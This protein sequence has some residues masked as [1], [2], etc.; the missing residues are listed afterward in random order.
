[1]VSLGGIV[2]CVLLGVPLY[3]ARE[4]A[5]YWRKETVKLAAE[6]DEFTRETAAPKK[7]IAVLE[8]QKEQMSEEIDRLNGCVDKWADKASF[9]E[10]KCAFLAKEVL[11]LKAAAK[12]KKAKVSK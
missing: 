6:Y 5:E 3:R 7:D 4:R 9:A 11:R 10:V 1:L 12:K 8:A 2:A